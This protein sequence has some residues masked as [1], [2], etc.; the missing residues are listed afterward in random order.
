MVRCFS[1]VPEGGRENFGQCVTAGICAWCSWSPMRA[2][3]EMTAKAGKKKD[4]NAK[5]D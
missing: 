2:R 3:A 5:P 4:A 1:C